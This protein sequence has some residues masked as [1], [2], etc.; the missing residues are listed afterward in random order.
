[1]ISDILQIVV[2]RYNE[3]ISW[4][5]EFKDICKIYNKGNDF[6]PYQ[7]IQLENIGREGDTYLKHIILNYPKFPKYTLFTQGRINDHVKSELAFKTNIRDIIDGNRIPNSYEGLSNVSVNNGWNDIRG[8]N[9]SAHSGLPIKAWWDKFFTDPPENDTF[10]CNYSGIFLVPNKS[11]TFHSIEFYKELNNYL[12][13]TEPTGGYVLER[14][15][16]TIFGQTYKSSFDKSV[17]PNTYTTKDLLQIS[18]I[19]ISTLKDLLHKANIL[20]NKSKI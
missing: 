4:L 19:N 17:L 14:L 5:D 12:L 2:A 1:M 20:C 8:Y 9:D 18:Y 15:W 10:K 13:E 3:N 6:I 16:T 7:C 11:I